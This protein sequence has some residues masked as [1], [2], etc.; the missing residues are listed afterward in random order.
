VLLRTKDDARNLIA[1]RIAKGEHLTEELQ[2]LSPLTLQAVRHFQRDQFD[3]WNAY[4]HDLLLQLF[5]Q[6]KYS[7]EYRE[8]PRPFGFVG[9]PTTAEQDRNALVARLQRKLARLR[10]LS[11]RLEII[12]VSP[13]MQTIETDVASRQ[14]RSGAK[15]PAGSRPRI[16]VGSSTESLYIAYAVQTNLEHDAEVTVWSQGL[17]KLSQTSVTSL[18]SA[19]DRFDAA[20]FVFTPDDVQ[21]MRD[22]SRAAVRDNVIFEFGL[23][24]GSLG[25]ERTFIIRP[26]Q[27][28]LHIPTDLWGIVPADYAPDR[29][30]DNWEAALG[31]ACHKIRTQLGAAVPTTTNL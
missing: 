4:N 30:D 7:D 21:I 16:F 1:D 8:K 26:R 5:D 12:P 3:A 11:D 22:E 13:R 24:M 6:P 25:S 17:F 19:L 28:E 10:S 18:E 29:S 14:R 2:G 27:T 15:R 20:I 23:F 9:D 31:P